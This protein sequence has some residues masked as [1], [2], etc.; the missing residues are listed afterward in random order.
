MQHNQSTVLDMTGERG[1]R[2]QIKHKQTTTTKA[3]ERG[4]QQ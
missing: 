1:Q 2:N 4:K 3:L